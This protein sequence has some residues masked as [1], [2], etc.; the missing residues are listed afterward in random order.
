MH[1]RFPEHVTITNLFSIIMLSY[2][3]AHFRN[4]IIAVATVGL[5]VG[6]EDF[7]DDLT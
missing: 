4:W 7:I 1:S 2:Y 6:T 3:I 5:Y